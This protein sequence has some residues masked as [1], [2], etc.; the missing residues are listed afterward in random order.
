M[1]EKITYQTFLEKIKSKTPFSFT[2]YGDGEWNAVFGKQ[3]SNCDQHQYFPEMGKA[4]VR[5]LSN[6]PRYFLGMQGLGYRQRTDQ[7]NELIS[8][9]NLPPANQWTDADILHKASI[10]GNLMQ[11]INTVNSSSRPRSML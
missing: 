9:F 2:R 10:N 11:F 6:S 7:I 3:G 5:C 1:K 8:E 4:L